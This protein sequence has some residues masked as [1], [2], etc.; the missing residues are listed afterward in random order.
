MKKGATKFVLILVLILPLITCAQQRW[1]SDIGRPGETESCDYLSESYDNGYMVSGSYW[2]EHGMYYKTSINGEYLW[3]KVFISGVFFDKMYAHFEFPAGQKIL[4]GHAGP[5]PV[6]I[7]LN[8]CGELEWCYTYRNNEHFIGG[9]FVDVVSIDEEK[10]LGLAVMGI[11]NTELQVYLFCFDIS[12]QLL[13]MKEVVSVEDYPDI[14]NPICRRIDK[15]SGEYFI[16]GTCYYRLPNNPDAF[17]ERA[18]F[19]KVDT[20][21]N[22][23]W[24]LPYGQNLG[25]STYFG[26]SSGVIKDNDSIMK[27]FGLIDGPRGYEGAVMSFSND[28]LETD[29]FVIRNQK[30]G[31]SLKYNSLR[32]LLKLND[33]MY[34]ASG[35]YAHISGY[36]MNE[37]LVSKSGNVYNPQFYLDSRPFF[38][39]VI[40]ASDSNFVFA[41]TRKL[42]DEWDIFMY[43]LDD[44]LNS[45]V[46]VPDDTIIYDYLCDN[47]PILSDTIDLSTCGILT[48]TEEI[49][50]PDE[51]FAKLKKLSLNVSPNPVNTL[52][53][54]KVGD[55]NHQAAIQL[56][57]YHSSGQLVHEQQLPSGQ[58]NMVID[59]SSWQKGMYIAVAINNDGNKGSVKFLVNN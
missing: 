17:V 51:Y 32:G 36:G 21:F 18:M 5:D 29:Y 50:T 59:V 11:S 24:L 19:I 58:K 35:H 33:T 2:N 7:S 38:Q 41:G 25:S 1:Q 10:I 6:M 22:E 56:R 48:G 44:S 43:K 55:N 15:I 46:L 47:L 13:W 57:F 40:R 49:P 42:E 14:K 3:D 54:L 37:Y 23:A 27:G 26:R 28:G 4:A 20:T 39:N 31:D 45:V 12:G 8:A 34:V 53:H 30:L 16:S 52:L 9:Y